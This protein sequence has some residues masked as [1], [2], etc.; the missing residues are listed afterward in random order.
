MDC[1]P[2]PG[3][4]TNTPGAKWHWNT[5]RQPGLLTCPGS[6]QRFGRLQSA[7]LRRIHQRCDE[8]H[9]PGISISAC[10]QQLL[11]SAGLVVCRGRV[12]WAAGTRAGSQGAAQTAQVCHILKHTT[13]QGQWYCLQAAA[14]DGPDGLAQRYC[15]NT[16]TVSPALHSAPGGVNSSPPVGIC[17][18][19]EQSSNHPPPPACHG[20]VQGHMSGG[21]ARFV[22]VS[23]GGKQLP[24]LRSI[25]G[26]RG[27][28]QG[29]HVHVCQA[30]QAR[31]K[32]SRL[33]MV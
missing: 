16:D 11:H 26:M 14:P 23:A 24:H 19:F 29:R 33:L 18:P 30:L 20:K 27:A 3:C 21:P 8:L 4:Q 25:A 10:L 15:A 13:A 9:A 32:A 6:Q 5:D 1:R 22:G 17:P 12:Q 2:A 7:V 31:N 28:V